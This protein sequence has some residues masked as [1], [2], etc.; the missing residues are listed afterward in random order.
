[1][2]KTRKPRLTQPQKDLIIE[3]HKAGAT[4]RALATR[5]GVCLVTIRKAIAAAPPPPAAEPL[6]AAEPDFT[7][8]VLGIDDVGVFFQQEHVLIRIPKK[9]FVQTLLK[10]HI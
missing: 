6:A 5:F 10:D 9:L 2:E 7:T 8:K 4:H 1:M 3:G